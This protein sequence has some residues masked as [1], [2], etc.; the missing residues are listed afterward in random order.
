MFTGIV[1]EVGTVARV[2]PG[3]RAAILRIKA[4][5]VTRDLA[6]GDSVAVNGCCLTVVAHD[7]A[8][9]S[10]EAVHE[11][12]ERSTA[13]AL[14]AGDRVN[15]ER[16]LAVGGRLGG[17]IVS[18][19]VDGVGRVERVEA[20]GDAR[21]FTISAPAEVMRYVVHKGSIAVDGISL[22]VTRAEAGSFTI[23][24]IPHTVASTTLA[25][26]RAG[27]AVN[28][29]SDVIGRY[30]ERLM[31]L[32]PAPGAGAGRAEGPAGA[33]TGARAAPGHGGVDADLLAR[34]GFM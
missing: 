11:T 5:V 29:E 15:L 34:F 4:G 22:T 8:A 33:P 25:E 7:A 32:G 9:F 3:A 23:S 24:V 6:L 30:V 17:H 26:R 18:G 1:E 19:H 14:G 10:V 28:L 12:L 16:A 13:G 27:D 31:G 2:T 20:D 21:L